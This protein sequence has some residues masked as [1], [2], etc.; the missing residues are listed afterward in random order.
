MVPEPGGM[1]AS[2]ALRRSAFHSPMTPN[3]PGQPGG[4]AL[5]GPQAGDEV[6]DANLR[7][8]GLRI[9]EGLRGV[10]VEVVGLFF[11]N[12]RGVGKTAAFRF[13]DGGF[14]A[15]LDDVAVVLFGPRGQRGGAASNCRRACSRSLGWLSPRAMR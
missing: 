6:A 5:S 13:D 3:Q 12:L 4:T 10:F 11:Q 1:S 7:P 15:P 2:R 9:D 8:A 14:Q